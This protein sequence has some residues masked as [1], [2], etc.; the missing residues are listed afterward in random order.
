MCDENRDRIS[1]LPP[2]VNKMNTKTVDV[3]S[4]VCKTIDVAFLRAPIK[5][6]VPIV[7]KFLQVGKRDAIIPACFCNFIR[8]PGMGKPLMQILENLFGYINNKGLHLHTYTPLAWL[9]IYSI[10]RLS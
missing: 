3:C 8:P 5:A 10:G 1:A 9:V 4:V 7:N 6:S 2:F